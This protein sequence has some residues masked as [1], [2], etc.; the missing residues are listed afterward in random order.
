M[1]ELL[2]NS[3][4][5]SFFQAV[6]LLTDYNELSSS[7]DGIK[8]LK[9]TFIQFIS[10]PELSHSKSDIECIEIDD[11]ED[12]LTARVMVNFMGLYGAVSPLPAFYSERILQTKND[13]DYTQHFMDL[14]NHRII[15]LVFN[16]WEKYRY[17]QVYRAGSIDNF[18]SWMFAFTG[19]F[20]NEENATLRADPDINWNRLLPFVGM[21]GMRCHSANMIES[22]L[23]YYFDIDSIEI[24]S[25]VKRFVEIESDQQNRLGNRCVSIDN[26]LVLGNIIEDRSGK[27]RIKISRLYYDQFSKYLPDGEYHI[28]LKKIVNFLLRDQLDYDIELQLLKYEAPALHLSNKNFEKLGWTSW[29]GNH[30]QENQ[31]VIIPGGV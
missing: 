13:A 31:S 25:N 26:N 5:Y 19:L 4:Q 2:V 23:K 3:Q 28:T 14:F 1:N 20:Q 24:I 27:F 10:N 7:E 8:Q 6:K 30:E 29:I 9:K 21:L 15:A 22:I 16:C 11:A 17:C 18:S 12:K